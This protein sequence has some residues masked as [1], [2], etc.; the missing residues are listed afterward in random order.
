[1]N[2]SP[3]QPTLFAMLSQYG[4][5]FPFER[6]DAGTEPIRPGQRVT[7]LAIIDG[8]DAIHAGIEAWCSDADPPISVV[9][10][11]DDPRKFLMCCATA[12][13]ALF[14][15]QFGDGPPCFDILGAVCR[16]D[17]R[18]I[19]YS[20]LT[21]DEVILTSL[22]L[23]AVTYLVKHA[24]R[25]HLI[26]AVQAARSPVPYVTPQMAI[27]LRNACALGRTNLSRRER[28]V[29]IAWLQAE[30]KE[31]AAHLLCITPA[32]VRTH[33]QRIREKYD[34]VGRRAPTKSALLARAI[35]DGLLGVADL[36]ANTG[37][38]GAHP[39]LSA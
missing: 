26:A 10:A 33:L 14:E 20:R 13:V 22:D 16:S 21:A 9:G 28:E 36:S 38:L 4:D 24:S 15:L 6:T 37:N 39:G 27:A 7:T 31:I 19:V 35:E 1:M 18:V 11:F 5:K 25:Q 2:S 32:T 3:P 34:A 30:S 29:L 12:D 23:G 17:C 8:H